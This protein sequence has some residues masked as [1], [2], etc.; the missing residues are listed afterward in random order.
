MKTGNSIESKA[1]IAGFS[2]NSSNSI[3]Q[4]KKRGMEDSCL[5]RRIGSRGRE[6]RRWR[7]GRGKIEGQS[8][9]SNVSR[10]M[11]CVAQ[12]GKI[13]TIEIMGIDD[14]LFDG[15]GRR[16]AWGWNCQR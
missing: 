16:S 2:W 5:E 13:I 4:W 12:V 9:V 1:V 14:G 7:R 11:I 8:G 15:R 3:A 10:S 6:G